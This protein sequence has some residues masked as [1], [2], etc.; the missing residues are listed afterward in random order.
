[1][2]HALVA[3]PPYIPDEEWTST[4]PAKAVGRNVK[5]FEPEIALRGGADGLAFVRPILERGPA[6]LR[7]GGM[8]LVEIAASTADEVMAIAAGQ[9]DL[10]SPRILDDLEGHPRVLLARR[11]P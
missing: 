6:R 10:T 7:P 2:L 11:T 8:L 9:G 3:N 4:D 5:G 1:M